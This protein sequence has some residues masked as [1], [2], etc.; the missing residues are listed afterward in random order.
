MLLGSHFGGIWES[1]IK[2][3]K[4]RLAKVVG[5]QILTHEEFVTILAQIEYLLDSRPFSFKIV[6]RKTLSINPFFVYRILITVIG[7]GCNFRKDKWLL[8]KPK[9]YDGMYPHEQIYG[10]Y[11]ILKFFPLNP[12]VVS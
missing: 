9:T 8:N 11:E 4:L 6:T 1:N 7:S 2:S 10:L 12:V 5:K 3:T